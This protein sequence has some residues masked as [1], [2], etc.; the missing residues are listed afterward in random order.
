MGKHKSLN[1]TSFLLIQPPWLEKSGPHFASHL[2]RPCHVVMWCQLPVLSCK[3]HCKGPI[4]LPWTLS[5]HLLPDA[6]VHQ[7]F[8]DLSSCIVLD[9]ELVQPSMN[10][11]SP[12]PF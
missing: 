9:V 8:E 10:L 11:P 12:H 3:L 7:G 1:V 6:K 5:L 2:D 4:C